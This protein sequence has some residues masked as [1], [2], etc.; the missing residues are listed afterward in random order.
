MSETIGRV[1]TLGGL[2]P[3]TVAGIAGSTGSSSGTPAVPAN[4]A[5]PTWQPWLETHAKAQSALKTQIGVALAGF[6]RDMEEAQ[7]LLDAAEATAAAQTQQL[8][9]A[10]WAAWNH[11]MAAANAAHQAVM[12]AALGTYQHAIAQAQAR[13]DA[14]IGNAEDAYKKARGVAEW[15]RNQ[16]T[17]SDTF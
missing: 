4:A 11:Y 10:A 6:N 1:P 17:G 13:S 2:P 5:S 16:A 12:N 7:R 15:G 8:E 3:R 14:L 9:S